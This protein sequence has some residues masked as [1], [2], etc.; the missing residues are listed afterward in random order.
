MVRFMLGAL[1][2]KFKIKE[3]GTVFRT[4]NWTWGLQA[5]DSF[6]YLS[7][8]TQSKTM[9]PKLIHVS[10]ILTLFPSFCYSQE[11]IP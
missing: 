9:M 5:M 8:G 2:H 7:I 3:F 6:P 11:C 1:Y 10:R 4:K